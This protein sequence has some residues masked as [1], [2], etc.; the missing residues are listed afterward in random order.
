MSPSDADGMDVLDEIQDLV[1]DLGAWLEW[2]RL[3]GAEVVPAD[4]LLSGPDRR[5]LVQAL[6]AGLSRGGASVAPVRPPPGTAGRFSAPRT[7]PPAMAA[8]AGRNTQAR[9]PSQPSRAPDRSRSMGSRPEASI[10]RPEA[11]IK[12]REASD[13]R[14]GSLGRW[15]RFLG[16][17][18]GGSNKAGSQPPAGV[19]GCRRGGLCRV[20]VA[21]SSTSASDT[22]IPLMVIGEGLGSVSGSTASPAARPVQM[23]DRMLEN[24]LG[25][26]RSKVHITNVVAGPAKDSRQPPA[27]E[28]TLCRPCLL[29]QLRA[30]QP[31]L[32]LVLGSSACRAVFEISEDVERIRG[33]WR[34]LRFPGGEVQAM[35]SFHPA[36]LLQQ[37]SDKRKAFADLKA[38]RAAL[39]E[40]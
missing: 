36:H 37:P 31:K 4:G 38:V 17:D 6:S 9:A 25:L 3:G 24:V 39:D 33:R 12:R 29:K 21:T 27:E 30:V 26:P 35:P 40:G 32:V 10:K 19:G 5:A 16:N 23:L 22:R 28:P 13:K 11:S 2:T 20:Q 18:N 14:Q 34:P 7:A 1:D 8:G 15:E